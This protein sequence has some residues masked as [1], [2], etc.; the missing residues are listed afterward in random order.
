MDQVYSLQQKIR[1]FA[2]ITS[3]KKL[4]TKPCHS[5]S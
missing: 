4:D 2:Y 5:I 3:R 1:D